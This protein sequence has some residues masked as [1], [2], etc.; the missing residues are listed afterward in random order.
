MSLRL[1]TKWVACAGIA[2]VLA[3]GATGAIVS[4]AAASGSSKVVT[5]KTASPVTTADLTFNLSISGV[6]ASP[7]TITGNG[8][9]DFT[10]DAASLAVTIPASVAEKIPGGSDAPETVNAVLSGG[11]LYLEVPSLA[12]VVGE[13]WIS[14][15][16][17]TQATSALPGGFSKVASVLGNVN[18]ILTF[19][20]KHHATVTSLGTSTVNQ[21]QATGSQIA[22]SKTT[23]K[24][25]TV[26]LTG[27]VWADSSDRLVQGNVSVSGTGAKGT[28]GVTATVDLSGY[29]T[30]VT[31]TVPPSSEVKPV[32][33]SAVAKVFGTFLRPLRRV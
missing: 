24:G 18:A 9:V 3:V 21:T 2:G 11:T 12:S 1:T 25:T 6:S 32:P 8:E 26:T 27:T 29:G 10:N 31:I 28:A 17:P 33:Y 5:H 23:K 19:A 16:L 15:A 7:V 22:A 4:T 14:V 30:P 13:P 20:Q